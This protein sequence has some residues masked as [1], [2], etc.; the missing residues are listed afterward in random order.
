VT[1]SIGIEVG[2][3]SGNGLELVGAVV[4]NNTVQNSTVGILVT[5]HVTS[6]SIQGGQLTSN[7]LGIFAISSDAAV[8]PIV[9]LSVQN[10]QADNNTSDGF[11][12]SNLSGVVTVT[13]GSYDNNGDDG[14][15][16]DGDN[17]AGTQL[18]ISGAM[19]ASNNGD[20]GLFATEFPIG[21]VAPQVSIDDGT[22][23]DNGQTT[24]TGDG[25]HLVA[26]GD[27]IF[28]S[29]EASGNDPGVLI[30]GAA[31][32][33]DT[34]G[35]FSDN[36]DHGIQLV[37]IAGDVVLTLT[38]AE[39]ND[40]DNDDIGD[41][42]NAT[43]NVNL[44]AI[45]GSLTISGGTFRDTD[46]G[47]PAV[48]QRHGVF[49][50]SVSGTVTLESSGLTPMT[51]TGNQLDGVN[52][53]GVGGNSASLTG[54]TYS[55]NGADGGDGID[56]DNFASVTLDSVTANA[57]GDFGFA[58]S[59]V[60]GT[61][62]LTDLTLGPA[63]DLNGSGGGDISSVTTV[64]FT[65]TTTPVA[66]SDTVTITATQFQHDRDGTL[67][68][69]VTYALVTDLIVNTLDGTDTIIVQGTNA[70]TSN[71]VN[72]GAANDTI[73]VGN[74][75]TLD[76]IQGL[77]TVNGNG[78]EAVLTD[79]LTAT[80][81]AVIVTNTLPSGDTLNVNDS[82][83]PDA[84][85][86][87][88]NETLTADTV[89]RTGAAL[90]TYATVETVILSAGTG[91]DTIDVVTT[92][93]SVN[94][95]INTT[96]GGDAVNVATTGAT[97][98]LEVNG[99]GL[100]NDI[101]ITTTGNG[102]VTQVNAAGDN[103]EIILQGNGNASGILLNGDAGDDNVAVQNTTGTSVT[104]VS[105]GDDDDSIVV[106]STVLTLDGLLGPL[107]VDGDGGADTLTVNDTEDPTGDIGTLTPTT[108]S[109]ISASVI[110]Y[111]TMELLEINLGRGA[112]DFTITNTHSGSTRV[113][114]GQALVPT[115]ADD[116]VITITNSSGTTTVD[117]QL[118]NDLITSGPGSDV[119]IGGPGAPP[120]NG[121][122]GDTDQDGVLDAGETWVDQDTLACGAGVDVIFFT[123][124]ED[125][126]NPDCDDAQQFSEGKSPKS[127]IPGVPF[128]GDDTSEVI[129]GTPGDDTIDGAGGDDFIIARGGVD[130]VNGGEGDDTVKGGDGDDI[131]NGG[132][133]SDGLFGGPDEDILNGE[134]GA[135]F[136][137]GG[138]GG[139]TMFGGTEGDV[140]SDLFGGDD[141]LE[142]G[143]GNDTL[144]AGA[145]DDIVR[146]DGGADL[147]LDTG[148]IKASVIVNAVDPEFLLFSP[149]GGNDDMDG[150]EGDDTINGG[151]GDDVLKGSAG[152]D[153]IIDVMMDFVVTEDANHNGVL[154]PGEDLNENN[155]LD[156]SF[157]E[158]INNNGQLDL[159]ITEDI[160]NNGQLDPGEDINGNG[161][162]DFLS[163]DFN[164]NNILDVSRFGAFECSTALS[165][166]TLACAR[167]DLGGDDFLDG[168]PG[169][170]T[171]A[172]GTG[173]DQVLGGTG[174]DFLMGSILADEHALASSER[175]NS[176]DEDDVLDAG[177]GDGSRDILIDVSDSRQRL[178]DGRQNDFNNT[179]AID[180]VISRFT[181]KSLAQYSKLRTTLFG[182]S[183]LEAC[184]VKPRNSGL[185]I[186]V[187]DPIVVKAPGKKAITEQVERFTS[188]F[189]QAMQSIIGLN[190][191]V[192]SKGRAIGP[193]P[194]PVPVSFEVPNDAAL[195]SI[196]ESILQGR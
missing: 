165:A 41:G 6:L 64:D 195:A 60:S 80:C 139:D 7:V 154:D 92:A 95:T 142:G 61:L 28:N 167:A 173:A 174:A 35:I 181:R 27:V 68:Q 150:G 58:V 44:Q 117:G 72:A 89:Q 66:A 158:D 99:D 31:S 81:N 103:D 185:T 178:N 186:P 101:T 127:V 94:T 196:L 147:L 59:N 160:N 38:T 156:L 169:N 4:S 182:S 120:P 187:C 191:L 52:I 37:D 176:F 74:A 26:V 11:R 3:T 163:E 36:E 15:D 162:I 87:T 48:H 131:V 76:D 45:G 189:G 98:N 73:E 46:A 16:I 90:I 177:A 22:F 63:P 114:G 29:V 194:A 140:L 113:N 86:Y 159:I 24:A 141:L 123:P 164:G 21:G 14:L 125:T 91:T 161:T 149:G 155:Q 152:N 5:D 8:S 50:A 184:T 40:S 17:V 85:T 183:V 9:D 10:V 96:G 111:D 116:D 20:D 77:V 110:I 53:T 97:S 82:A 122:Q 192:K 75:G 79:T 39:N 104:E 132:N 119:L 18:I 151:P 43:A 23:N 118:G 54:G 32:F 34:N 78:N 56:L 13:G 19:S 25:I 144:L 145:G 137:E 115:D 42:L 121:I 2:N 107:C 93:D 190:P 135:D 130:S 146:G 128:V 188:G 71:T 33:S 172:G 70:T 49:V 65:S 193:Q 1:E 57:N 171:L 106:G 143:D 109:G 108:L 134:A 67:H 168:G 138:L 126:V 129:I 105:G 179:E 30:T 153:M 51:V 12:G 69:A 136:L 175:F 88:L 100:V 180:I 112:D 124:L 170:D 148:L 102:S 62:F 157:T 84:N 83:D 47:G 133:G 55:N 166:F